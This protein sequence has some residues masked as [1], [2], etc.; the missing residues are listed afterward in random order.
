MDDKRAGRLAD[1]LSNLHDS[2]RKK[3]QGKPALSK[4]A[5]LVQSPT[6]LVLCPI[7]YSKENKAVVR[8]KLYQFFKSPQG[9]TPVL[10]VQVD[11]KR[12]WIKLIRFVGI[13][14]GEFNAET[15][16]LTGKDV[17][18]YN[19]FGYRYEHPEKAGDDHC[20]FHVQPISVT[21]L[22]ERIP[23]LPDWLS[24]RF[25]TFYMQA[26]NS[27]ELGIYA[28][29]SLCSW[30]DLRSYQSTAYEDCWLLDHLIKQGKGAL[31]RNKRE[32]ASQ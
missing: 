18:G 2:G 8:S 13:G 28:L 32:Q 29:S 10:L 24:F 3:I 15:I 1:F 30:K 7:N 21:C 27:Y 16:S 14:N 19:G 20:F 31:E 4:Y 17:K 26:G 5:K 11:D 9:T 23:G 6:S 22:D 12:D 25:P